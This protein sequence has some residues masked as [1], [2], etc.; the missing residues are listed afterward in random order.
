V[1][2]FDPEIVVIGGGLAQAS[3]LF[4]NALRKSMKERAQPISGKQVRVVASELA[5]DANLLG[6][7]RLAGL[8]YSDW[9]PKRKGYSF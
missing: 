3:D 1:S 5:G 6:V 9:E 8:T 2:L 4:L 7:A